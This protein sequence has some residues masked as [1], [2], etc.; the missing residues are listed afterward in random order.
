MQP[1]AGNYYRYVDEFQSSSGQKVGRTRLA[2]FIHS[3]RIHVSILIRAEGRMQPEAMPTTYNVY[4]FQSSSGQKA[5]CNTSR[6]PWGFGSCSFNPH[7]ARRPDATRLGD[8]IYPRP[9][10]VSILIRPEGR[11]QHPIPIMYD[12]RNVHV[13]IL[14]RP[15]GRMQRQAAGALLLRRQV[16]ILIRPEGRM[17]PAR[18][19]G[20]AYASTSFNPH[21]ARRPDATG[22]GK[23]HPAGHSGFNPH[24]ARRPDATPSGHMPRATYPAFQSSSGQKAGCNPLTEWDARPSS[25]CFNPHLARRPDATPSSPSTAWAIEQFQSSSGLLAGCKLS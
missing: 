18:S 22:L 24:P 19:S 1:V 21:P 5:G 23:A 16:S 14:I 13:S 8:V 7:P 2:N 15:E 12:G 10:Y 4:T 20:I 6:R 9:P 11:M 3:F 25:A 17:Q